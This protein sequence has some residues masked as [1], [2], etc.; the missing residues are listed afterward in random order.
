M[1][2]SR[3][4]LKAFGETRS[5]SEWTTKFDISYTRLYQRI[6]A[7]WTVEKA[8]QAPIHRRRTTPARNRRTNRLIEYKGE[9][10]SLAEWCEITGIKYSTLYG[11]LQSGW[12]IADVFNINKKVNQYK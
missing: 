9:T 6:K 10:K 2:K 4:Q 7:G 11:R 12:P 5:I 3:I 8:L 1:K